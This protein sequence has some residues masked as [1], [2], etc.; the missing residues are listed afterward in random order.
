MVDVR[1]VRKMQR[2]I[3][4]EEMRQHATGALSGMSLLNR[5]RLSVQQVSQQHADF[6]FS[7]EKL[8][9]AA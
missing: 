9:E 6:I 7:L 1:F 8:E 2:F 5:P 4:L 3:P